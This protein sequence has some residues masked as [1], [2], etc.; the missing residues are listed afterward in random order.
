MNSSSLLSN[1][2]NF[3]NIIIKF[4]HWWFDLSHSPFSV[5]TLNAIPWP[6]RVSGPNYTL[7]S[8][9][10][11]VSKHLGWQEHDIHSIETAQMRYIQK[12][13]AFNHAY[14]LNYIFSIPCRMT[15]CCQ[16]PYSWHI[17]I[18]HT[19]KLT[20]SHFKLCA[21]LYSRSNRLLK[22]CP[23]FIR[24]WCF[25]HQWRCRTWNPSQI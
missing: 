23:N 20:S 10:Y 25:S 13:L 6:M 12:Y 2:V 8:D 24:T 7:R 22:N 14:L 18:I 15:C 21:F 19:G 5:R 1:I 11:Q 3:Q 17:N 4:Q 9:L 16:G